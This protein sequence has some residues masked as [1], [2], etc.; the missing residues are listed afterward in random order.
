M[1]K[2]VTIA[3]II[4]ANYSFAQT[5]TGKLQIE[6]K[7]FVFGVGLGAGSLSLNTNDTVSTK[8]STA[9]PN[10]KVGYMLN[11]RLALLA[12]LPGANYNYNEKD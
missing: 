2:I 6:R 8:L 11:N 5:N 1:R 9:L 12:I 10:I 3:L 7:G 4:I